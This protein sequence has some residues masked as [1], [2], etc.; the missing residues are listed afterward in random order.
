[1]NILSQSMRA[2]TTCKVTFTEQ[3]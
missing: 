2:P 3:I 1:M